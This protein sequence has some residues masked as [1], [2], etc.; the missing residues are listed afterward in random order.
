M[1][2]RLGALTGAVALTATLLVT[3]GPTA[4]AAATRPA[5][6]PP[7]GADLSLVHGIP[8]LPVDIYVARDGA[9]VLKFSDVTFGTAV[10]VTEADPGF[11]TG[12]FYVVDVVRHGASP[13]TPLLITAFPLAAGQSK[14][15]AAY[16][17][18]SSTG[19]AGRQVLKVFTNNVR[20]TGPEA[21]LTVRHLA[22]APAVAVRVDGDTLTLGIA[23]GQ[24]ASAVEQPGADEVTLAAAGAPGT[25]IGGAMV[26]LRPSTDTQVFAVGTYPATFR[27]V[28]VDSPIP[29]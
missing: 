7:N 9:D 18:A 20:P 15:V 23:N 4:G 13:D 27:L 3:G 17:S 12:G 25:P 19:V 29:S 2:R 14:T 11:V 8:H 16:V 10:D 24:T 28:T 5:F 21:R 22:V 26:E 1:R 6:L